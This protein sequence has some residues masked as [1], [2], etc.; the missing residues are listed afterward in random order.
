MKSSSRHW[1]CGAAAIVALLGLLLG[2]CET[3]VDRRGAAVGGLDVAEESGD[4]DSGVD[5]GSDGGSPPRPAAP[6][7]AGPDRVVCD[8]LLSVIDA[9]CRTIL[10][11]PHCGGT[12]GTDLTLPVACDVATSLAARMGRY[13]SVCGLTPAQAQH[14]APCASCGVS[15]DCDSLC[16]GWGRYCGPTCE[17]C[18]LAVGE[19]YWC[20]EHEPT[21]P[22][23]PFYCGGPL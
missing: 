8:K 5:S 15:L 21:G 9:Q 17:S 14:F 2:G 13:V 12:G 4:V 22:E 10:E 20:T 1:I 18:R 19:F 11:S 7:Q 16:E 23:A 6:G 3:E